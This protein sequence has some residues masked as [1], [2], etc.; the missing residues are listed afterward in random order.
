M[1]VFDVGISTHNILNIT[2]AARLTFIIIFIPFLFSEANE[3]DIVYFIKNDNI[4]LSI[5]VRVS[6]RRQGVTKQSIKKVTRN[7][8]KILLNFERIKTI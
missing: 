7:N 5:M 8:N 6:V 2:H 4:K 3:F 1:K